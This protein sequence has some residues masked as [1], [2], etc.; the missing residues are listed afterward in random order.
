MWARCVSHG[1]KPPRIG[2]KIPWDSPKA[3]PGILFVDPIPGAAGP[4]APATA[5]PKPAAT[6]LASTPAT[7]GAATPVALQAR[8]KKATDQVAA[9][10][11]A[12]T[13]ALTVAKPL[14]HSSSEAA[15][16]DAQ[17]LLQKQHTALQ[18]TQKSLT[19]D[20]S[21][22]RKGG[23]SSTSSVT[24]LSKLSPK[25]RTL[26][27]GVTA[28]MTRVKGL[29]MKVQM[30]AVNAKKQAEAA[31]ANQAAE[32]RDI[33]ELD[34]ALPAVQELLSGTE[35]CVEAI[36]MMAV[37]LIEEPPE[38]SSDILKKALEEIEASANDAQNKITEARRQINAVLQNARKFAPE[39]KKKAQTEVAN[40][41]QK[42]TEAQKK[43]NPYKAFKKEFHAR[44]QARKSLQDLTEKLH[45]AELEA[46]KATMM[47]S[48]ADQGQMS[49][50]EIASAEKVVQPAKA[51]VENCLRNV[52]QKLRT[53]DGAMK[54]ELTQMREKAM[55]AK[56]KLD[57]VITVLR[58]QRES[59]TTKE[60]LKL[61]TDKVDKAEE[62]LGRCQEAEMPFLKGIEVLPKDESA[63]AIGESEAAAAKSDTAVAHARTF[64]KAKLAEA[65]KYVKELSTSVTE[66]LTAHQTRL[67]GVATKVA[68]FKKETA[69]RKMAA[70][71]AE[72]VDAIMLCEKKVEAL[73][74]VADIFSSENLDAVSTEDLKEA[75][76]K[77]TAAEKDAAAAMLEARKV[78]SQK[79]KE[80]KA[81]DAAAAL[82][83]L[84]GRISTA[85]QE[86][87]K[88]KKAAAS[89]EKLIKGKEV[90][91]EE[92]V[93]IKQ[94]EEEV[95]KAEKKVIP[96]EEEAALGI[97]SANPSDEDI[98]AMGITLSAAQK[99]IKT[100]TRI[101]EANTAGAPP[102]VKGALQ[103]LADRSKAIQEKITK[104]LAATKDQRERIT[105][106]A[107]VKEGKE[108]IEEVERAIEKVN[109]AELPFLKGIEVLPLKE[110]TDT[111]KDSEAAAAA[112]QA[113]ASAA[114]TF[115]ASKNLEIRHFGEAASKPAAEDFAQ[116]T[117]RINA[118]AAKL[119]QFRKDTE[120]R[121]KTA[122]MQEAG[123]KV[124][125]TEA[126]V[127]KMAEAV[128][129][130]AQEEG[131][132]E[133][134]E[135][136][137][138]K[139]V[140]QLKECQTVMDDA[141]NFLSARQK[142]VKG[143]GPRTEA[144]KL[145]LTRLSEAQTEMNKHR[146][147]AAVHEQKYLS[148][149]LVAEATEKLAAMEE[150]IEK[151]V[152]AC[153]PLL[154]EGG[155]RFLVAQSVRTL[156]AAL[157]VHMKAK[158]L[159]HEGMY[160]EFSSS[161]KEAFVDYLE[162]L[163]EAIGHEEV[164]FSAPRR[165]AMFK[166]IDADGDGVIS[167][168]EFKE[169]FKQRFECVKEISLT[170]V[171]EVSKSKTT[172]K[173]AAGELLETVHG[174]QVDD[175]NGM[176]RIEVTVVSTG[177][178]GFV[179]M[180][181]NQGT[182]YIELV[183]PFTTFCDELN[184][185]VEK[186]VTNVNGVSQFFSLKLKPP[187]PVAG[188]PAKDNLAAEARKELAKLRPRLTKAQETMSMLK[189]KIAT[190]R[191]DFAKKELAEKHAYIEAK[192][193]KAAE[194]LTGPAAAQVEAME[195]LA[196]SLEEAAKPLVS[197]DAA[198]LD[199][200]ATPF[201]IKEETDRLAEEALKSVEEARKTIAE[202]QAELPKIAKGPM[203]EA[204]QE[205]QK[206]LQKTGVTK[207][208]CLAVK[209][210]VRSKCLAIVEA[211]KAEI[212]SLLRAEAT[213]KE[214][215]F[216][217][218]FLELVTP[219]DERISEE[220]FCRSI[221]A[222]QGDAFKAE[223]A[224]LLCR[225]IEAGG[226]GRRRFQ[227]FL[228][229]YFVVVK[230]IAITND[231]DISK[232]KTL[233][234]AEVEEVV[235]LVEGPRTDE[236]LGVTRIRGKSLS[237]GVEGWVSV[238]GNQ[239]TPFLK[240]V[241]KPFYS[242][243]TETALE[244]EFKS[245]GE[246]ALLRMLKAEEVLEL[247]EGPRKVTFDPAVRVKGKACLDGAMGWF[248]SKDKTGQVFAEADCKYF[249]CT[250]SVA[251]TDH[252]DIK[253]CKVLRKLAVGEIFT[254]EEG[255]VEEKEAGITRVKGKSLKDETIGWITIKGNA[256]TV[257]AEASSK[258]YCV[259]HDVPLTK[260]F[261]SDKNNEVVRTLAKGEAMQVLQGPKEETFAPEVRVKCKAMSDG[262]VGWLTVKVDS[263]KPWTPFYRCKVAAPLHE[264]LSAEGATVIRQVEKG[265][266]VELLEG[267]AEDGK[268]LRMKGRAE[269]DG[270]I[271]WVTV[272][273]AEG[274]RLFES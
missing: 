78:Y 260:Q 1:D 46:E 239:G 33:K 41:Q 98:E 241:D 142:D 245:D 56:K 103:K 229:Q 3:E 120:A 170:D 130:F 93:K 49:E 237:D 118:A 63:K 220:A 147:V 66:E 179:T 20:I 168:D 17:Q 81:P 194:A 99:S 160:S 109:A 234:K 16:N 236:K 181:G 153:A 176:V 57:A 107:Y 150:S 216:E 139:L 106:E 265:E 38:D 26:Q 116:L 213:K 35:E 2:W 185:T 89:G 164:A 250:S 261:A 145:L 222:L 92:D 7:G 163:P 40:M 174:P 201:S 166:Y 80:A 122:Q 212:S 21:E 215:P 268:E 132:E 173:A 165:E 124:A 235:E 209:S 273:D 24:E 214:I 44:V 136:A 114:R 253:D 29:L 79:Q 47:S 251:M 53:A 36:C 247:L 207:K 256:G 73:S 226:I 203:F 19:L 198:E 223:Q 189:I 75:V 13:E 240:E 67:E 171:L 62:S 152:E 244:R 70:L 158:G 190:A 200:F 202:Q 51:G 148:K 128:E 175:S 86:L 146:K 205:L 105:S 32:E 140:T 96:G 269:K 39:A 210:G 232:A 8:V 184:V 155:E 91:A 11:A 243:T 206:M 64:L 31:A 126:E 55:A 59:L 37:P 180:Q 138:E 177:K 248:T 87:A 227:A 129:P 9:L 27:T 133:P 211:R 25:L 112:V 72:V 69:E 104:L 28:E 188:V 249:S 246:E 10:D 252:M 85:Q 270:A 143:D 134:S 127:K 30:G 197:L 149:K 88:H 45:T 219:G 208:Q 231:F 68:N 228:Q 82:A 115:L 58:R 196:K 15:L 257:Y 182:Q 50:D 141:R 97:E 117:E 137:C 224:K 258:H 76:D 230:A 5:P 218:Y 94:L 178:S 195:A 74:K 199:V 183:S 191:K 121:K 267:P 157:R 204:K 225:H 221:E 100:S 162:K 266:V 110:A 65:K 262:L 18:E 187:Q 60:M 242:C 111:I 169:I 156:A 113:A 131:A 154:E 254:V 43:L 123:E 217:R 42:L 54:D 167:M 238:K 22:A 263:M 125:A 4:S 272:K 61:A 172:A 271:G 161:S 159:S 6:P 192:D 255:P 71:L 83:K 119:G 48:A 264:A 84:Q 135:E 52:D 14:N 77:T 12:C 102:S 193:R 186:T 233:R 274:K 23:I 90:L 151:T 144:L 259:L 101:V 108:K 34:A 95:A